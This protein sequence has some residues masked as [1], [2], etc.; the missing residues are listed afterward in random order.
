[1]DGLR[2]HAAGDLTE[3]ICGRILHQRAADAEDERRAPGT[4]GP[5]RTTN[6]A[7]NAVIRMRLKKTA[8]RMTKNLRMRRLAILPC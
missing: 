4:D 8:K 7:A 5:R 1:V 6:H 2:T 3:H